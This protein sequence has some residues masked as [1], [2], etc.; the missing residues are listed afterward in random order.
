MKTITTFATCLAIGLSLVPAT[1]AAGFRDYITA[2]ESRLMEGEKPFRFISFNIPN[3]GYIEDDMQF[4]H[5]VNFR[6]PTSYEVDDALETI[7]QMGGRVARTYT[8]SIVKKTDPTGLPR[9]ILGPV[10]LNEGAMKVMDRVLEAANRKGVRLIIPIIDQN[11][12]WGGIEEFAAFSGKT[13]GEFFTDPQVRADYKRLVSIVLNRV[14]TRTHV[15]YMDDKA[16]LAWELGN[17]LV[18]PVQWVGEMASY[19]KQLDPRHLVAESY[20]TAA[21]NPGVDI[22]QDHLYQGDP[23]KMIQQI[24]NS[25][26]RA[27]GRRIYM[28]GEFGFITT[29]GMRA[30]MDT[31]IQDPGI[32]GGLIWSLRFHNQDGGFYWHHEP[33]GSDFFKAYHWPGGPTGEPYD[34]TR[35]MALV[36]GK[37]YEIQ[38]LT[39]PRLEIPS[40]PDLFRVTDGGLVTW[41]AATGTAACDLQRKAVSGGDWETVRYA[42]TDDSVQYHPM[43]VD[44]SALPGKSYAYRLV[45]RNQAGLSK[46]SQIVGP[47]VIRC[48]TLVDEFGN[49]SRTYR[50]GGKLE[51][52]S[53][54]ARNY[55]EDCHRVLGADGA[56]V[57]YH[58]PGRIVGARI[59][60]FGEKGEPA[61]Q[62]RTGCEGGHG[63]VLE[64]RASDSFAGKD[65]YNFRLPR[66]Y[67]LSALPGNGSNLLIQFEKE[68]QVGR[69]E[70]EYQ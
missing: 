23:A 69:V 6:L 33:W 5:P 34:E 70:I 48:R 57:A 7:R 26:G 65:M 18:A 36:R 42:L 13:K 19:I 16:V 37:A 45:A 40:A 14:N 43:A 12:W 63:D 35:F 8:L 44:E 10:T 55:K 49:F 61:L 4:D 31:I 52:K 11:S 68:T 30:I 41:R 60:A 64:S 39:P 9:H 20:F 47:V 29:E 28:V 1:S 67:T 46:P 62:F 21:D 22:V 53:N 50:K 25:V 32:S 24:Q 66:L 51:L 17:E 59:Y 56:W 38:G 54:D 27:Q 15:R 2:R 58:V 3:L